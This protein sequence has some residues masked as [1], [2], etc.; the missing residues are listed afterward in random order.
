MYLDHLKSNNTQCASEG[1]TFM[2]C[3]EAALY[4]TEVHASADAYL[5]KAEAECMAMSLEDGESAEKATGSFWDKI[6]AVVKKMWEAL[7]NVLA[8][9]LSFIKSVPGKIANIAREI[10]AKWQKIGL[11]KKIKEAKWDDLDEE[12]IKDLYY[13]DADEFYKVSVKS[14]FS[15]IEDIA[16]RNANAEEAKT[17]FEGIET[18][19]SDAY[20]SISSTKEGERH[21]RAVV[22]VTKANAK[23]LAESVAKASKRASDVITAA[24]AMVK[25][26]SDLSNKSV[27]E[28]QAI[29]AKKDEEEVKSVTAKLALYRRCSVITAKLANL[30]STASSKDLYSRASAV[31]KCVAAC[32]KSEE[33]K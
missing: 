29:Y 15:S 11:D 16:N 4:C 12:K 26:I 24:E 20:K 22:K 1:A 13:V 9:V 19:I 18:R 14:I 8:K 21:A 30:M 7:K 6:K 31:A 33:K 17:A 10:A 3:L 5:I 25:K 2:E 23:T 32:K 27:K 28:F